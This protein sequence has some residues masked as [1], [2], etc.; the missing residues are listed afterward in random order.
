MS[1]FTASRQ[2]LQ[3][4]VAIQEDMCRTQD[5]LHRIK[6]SHSRHDE[7]FYLKCLFEYLRAHPTLLFEHVGFRVRVIEKIND[8]KRTIYDG[9]YT[10]NRY[11]KPMEAAMK[12]VETLMKER[13]V[14]NAF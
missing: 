1:A 6:H 14:R 9:H 12:D 4:R 10:S 11:L 5:L 3:I 8:A 13:S 2:L 7:I